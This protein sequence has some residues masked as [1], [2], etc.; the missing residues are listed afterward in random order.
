MGI[1]TSKGA[2]FTDEAHYNS[3]RWEFLKQGKDFD[4]M[5]IEGPATRDYNIVSPEEQRTN[6]ALDDAESNQFGPG[7]PIANI[8]SRSP[9]SN[10]EDRSSEEY[11][12]NEKRNKELDN[13]YLP[14]PSEPIPPANILGHSLGTGDLDSTLLNQTIKQIDADRKRIPVYRAGGFYDKE[15]GFTDF[16][17]GVMRNPNSDGYI[18][19]PSESDR[20]INGYDYD[21]KSFFADNPNAKLSPGQHYPDTYKKPN[22]PTF[23]D[24]SR[25]HGTMGYRHPQTGEPVKPEG[26]HWEKDGD[27]WT[28]TPGRSNLE[29][30]T[31]QELIDYF[32][33]NEPD[34]KLILPGQ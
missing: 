1:G 15:K 25:Y 11:I 18:S 30:H 23:S 16:F 26:G 32:K 19:P 21:Y 13:S 8:P 5:E 2:F 22:H 28:F 14:D 12:V 27:Q 9:S 7:M 24:E 34:A 3:T 6:K 29:F 33:K 20:G 31:P 17:N 4:E 10:I